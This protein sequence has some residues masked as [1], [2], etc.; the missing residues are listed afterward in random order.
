V[1]AAAQA[2]LL[3]ELAGTTL[4]GVLEAGRVDP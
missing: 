3:V 2:A 1:F 4:A